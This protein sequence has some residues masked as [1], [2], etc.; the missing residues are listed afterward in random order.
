VERER[1][2]GGTRNVSKHDCGEGVAADNASPRVGAQT[3]G[4]TTE[5]VTVGGLLGMKPAQ[6]QFSLFSVFLFFVLFYFL[7]F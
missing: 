3:R 1:L 5:W 6:A 4:E 2:I 7:F